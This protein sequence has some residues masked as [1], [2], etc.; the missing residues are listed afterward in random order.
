MRW[1]YADPQNAVEMAER[2]AKL[3]QI[4]SWWL[5]FQNKKN[6]ISA[7]F[8]S[9]AKWDLPGW[10]EE[11]LQSIDP[12]IMWEFGPAVKGD[13][14]RLVITPE[15]R[16]DLRP[17]VRSILEK[18]P[19]IEGWEFYEYRLPEKLSQAVLA[20][21]GRTGVNIKDFKFRASLDQLLRIDMQFTSPQVKNQDDQ[22]A[23]NAAFV[24]LESLLGEERL[25]KW[26]GAIEVVPPPKSS[27]LMSLFKKPSKE[28]SDF[29]PMER[30]SETVNA[31]VGS[32]QDQMPSQ[33]YYEWVGKGES[34]DSA[35]WTMWELQPEQGDDYPEQLDLFVGKSINPALWTTAHN[36]LSF[37]SERFSRCGE[38]FVY[39]KIDG[40]DGLSEARFADKAEIEDAL[41]A[42]LTA[43]KLGC[44]IGGGTGL[45]YSYIDLALTDVQEA[46]SVIKQCLQEG[47]VPRRCWIQFFD[48]I[49]S[50]EWVGIYDDTPAP[51][52]GEEE[53]E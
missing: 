4:D 53:E 29:Y 16:K 30:L 20:V 48:S 34:E 43:A 9:K 51:P 31:L 24:T 44:V 5:T 23:I 41:D 22:E 1:L 19:A 42:L 3:M 26:I 38:V 27:G 45:R 50:K 32:V 10:M 15:V 11:H 39:L 18:A 7:L 14:H 12:S 17:L 49:Y 21:E 40:I 28:L 25:E 36:G 35:K 2:A 46:V 37:T 13:G 6:D 33:P 52:M 47:K 8:S